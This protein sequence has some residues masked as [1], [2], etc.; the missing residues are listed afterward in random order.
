MQLHGVGITLP[1]S[2]SSS[3]HLFLAAAKGSLEVR[4][5]LTHL[6]RYKLCL[7]LCTP[8]TGRQSK[9]HLQSH[10]HANLEACW[11]YLPSPKAILLRKPCVLA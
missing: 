4:D 1:C 10:K 11:P 7:A 5:S 2:A 8:Q 3:A 9:Q 6:L